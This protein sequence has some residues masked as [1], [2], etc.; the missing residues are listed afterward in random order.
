MERGFVRVT[1]EQAMSWLNVQFC[2][3]KTK[4]E[5]EVI[6]YIQQVFLKKENL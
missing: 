2:L 3:A 6:K 5:E 1:H 4:T